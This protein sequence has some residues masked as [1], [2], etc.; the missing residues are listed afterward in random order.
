MTPLAALEKAAPVRPGGAADAVDGVVPSWV[1]APASVADTA[2]VMRIAA[3]H[4]LS[5][6]PR[7]AGTRLRWG[8]PPASCDLLVDTGGLDKVIEHAAGDL[9]VTVE[10]GLTMDGL[11]EVLA[12]Q[13]QRLALDVPL[14]GSTVGG[15]LAT[16]AWGPLRLRYGTARDLLIGVT[17]VRADGGLAKAGGKVVKNVAGYDL[18]KLFTGSYGTL[19]LI[20]EAAFRLH[21]LPAARSYV[22]CEV[23]DFARAQTVVQEVLGSSVVPS[24]IELDAPGVGAGGPI[25]VTVLIE[26]VAAG[27]GARAELVAALL[28][29]GARADAEQPGWWGRYPDGP[30]L[31]EVTAP[32]AALADIFA[33]A[34]PALAALG[35]VGAGVRGSAGSGHWYVGVPADAPA[36]QA[37][38]L[39]TRLR[40]A[41]AGHGG[42]LVVRVAAPD[43]RDQVD[44]WGPVPS[45]PLMRRV[46]DQFDPGHRLAPG[47]FVGGI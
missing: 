29:A 17:I 7:G 5:V 43:L 33:P 16:G 6:V 1:A 37:A 38:E 47:R 32:P 12:A 13:G 21:P 28:G 26:G 45:L 41:A 10:A 11:A 3:E 35:A 14:A 27:V 18:G 20:V 8:L 25:T 36:E 44:P 46:K 9:V 19:G 4:G 2:E 30:T 42:S 15:T 22:T 34:S 39:V 31:L 23:A 24:A 40:A